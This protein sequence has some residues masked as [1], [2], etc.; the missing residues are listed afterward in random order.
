MG[1][2][3]ATIAAKKNEIAACYTFGSPRVGDEQWI[4]HIKTPIY[5][6]VNVADCVTMLPQGDET[7]PVFAWL[8]QFIPGCGSSIRKWLLAN[9]DGYLHGGSMRYLTNCKKDAYAQTKLSYSVSFWYRMK[10]FFVKKMSW[11]VFLS[12][13]SISVYRKKL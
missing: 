8:F 11:K 7:V 12:D 3:L 6:L 1:G 9:L 4:S 2:A 5:R 13:H 10:G